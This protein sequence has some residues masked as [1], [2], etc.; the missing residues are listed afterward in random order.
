MSSPVRDPNLAVYDSVAVAEHYAALEYL[1]PC[2]RHMFDTHVRAGAAVLE[3]GVGGGR[4]SN[5]LSQRASR[6]TGVDYAPRMVEACRRKYP[7]VDFRVGDASDLSAFAD[8]SFDSVVMAFNTIDCVLPDSARGRC[9]EEVRRVLKPAG[10]L[11]FS[12]HNPRAVLVAP[13]WNRE[14]LRLLAAR[15][16][17]GRRLS[18]KLAYAGL[19]CLRAALAVVQSLASSAGRVVRRVP[20]RAFWLGQGDLFDSSAHGGLRMH[21]W[22]PARCIAEL[23][24]Y[25]FRMVEVRGD[26]L[27]RRE[28]PLFTDWYYYAFAASTPEGVDSRCS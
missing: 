26:D 11:I 2:E 28:H 22:V 25:G 12:S 16:A 8:G 17:G 23:S 10:M 4:V 9:L 15:I 19:T 24:R 21:Y 20:S 14:R 7:G 13:A 18:G 27:P 3:I 1:T 5:Y 6:Y